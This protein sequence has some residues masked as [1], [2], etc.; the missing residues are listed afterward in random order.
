MFFNTVSAQELRLQRARSWSVSNLKN[1]GII[2]SSRKWQHLNVQSGSLYSVD[3]TL[4]PISS[5]IDRFYGESRVDANLEDDWQFHFLQTHLKVDKDEFNI[6][7]TIMD[8]NISTVVLMMKALMRWMS[9]TKKGMQQARLTKSK[10][11]ILVEKKKKCHSING[12]PLVGR[13]H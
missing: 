4:V 2:S 3:S 9:W 1:T 11:F 10:V 5:L 8:T 7:V 6:L 12:A 13:L